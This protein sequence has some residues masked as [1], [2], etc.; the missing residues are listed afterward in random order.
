MKLES[1]SN[2]VLEK[3]TI[4]MQKKRGKK[5]SQLTAV[6]LVAVVTAVVPVIASHILLDATLRG[7]TSELVQST[8]RLHVVI[9]SLFVPTVP[10]VQVTVA[11]LFFGYAKL[12]GS[13]D[14]SKVVRL[15]LSVYC[16]IY[17]ILVISSSFIHKRM[18]P[19]VLSIM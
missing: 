11:F 8:S 5:T 4:Q 1:K 17:H 6:F 16:N 14:T 15:A 2:D 10:A 12:R 13:S 3:Q 7:I 19:R 18:L 9:A